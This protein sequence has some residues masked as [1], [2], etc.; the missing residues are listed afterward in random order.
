[1]E[2]KNQFLSKEDVHKK[3]CLLIDHLKSLNSVV[4]AYSG[5]VDSTFL[6]YVLK[7]SRSHP[8][9]V[10][11]RSPTMPSDDLQTALKMVKEFHVQYRI[12]NTDECKD[13]NF[14][15]NPPDRCFYC[16][17][18]LFRRLKDIAIHEGYNNVID[19]S[20]ADDLDDYRPGLRAK[21]IYN[22]IRPLMDVNLGKEEIR[23]LSR[24][25]GLETWNK[26]SSPCLSSR[27]PYGEKITLRSLKMVEKAEK[28]LK[29]MG[30]QEL[31]VRK[32]GDAAR[33]EP[34][35]S[36]IEK[37]L[38]KDMRKAILSSLKDIGFLYITLDLEGYQMGKLNRGL[39]QS[40][41]R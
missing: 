22:I 15:N 25:K 11:A 4:L 40:T 29:K 30:F 2:H 37:F 28:A 16:K 21:E 24:E 32:H 26:P 14:V 1:M 5:G 33:I 13:D 36:D 12:I 34:L 7:E 31:R 39:R 3:Y 38:D 35:E 23:I 41:S 20:N 9:A 18:E 27:F 8:L 19:G 17:R 10:I 6:L